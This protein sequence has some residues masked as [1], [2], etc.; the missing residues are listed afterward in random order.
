MQEKAPLVMKLSAKR[1]QKNSDLTIDAMLLVVDVQKDVLL[2]IM[3]Y[4]GQYIGTIMKPVL[5]GLNTFLYVE[6]A[7]I[8]F[9]DITLY[10]SYQIL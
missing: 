1:P 2:I 4:M 6:K 10:H 9:I 5:F 7:V 8:I 3:E